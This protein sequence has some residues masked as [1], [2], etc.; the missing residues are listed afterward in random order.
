MRLLDE[1]PHVILSPCEML[2]SVAK[3]KGWTL[4]TPVDWKR[5]TASKSGIEHAALAAL[6]DPPRIIQSRLWRAQAAVLL[7]Q[8]ESQRVKIVRNNMSKFQGALQY[9]DPLD[10]ELSELERSVWSRTY[11]KVHNN[12]KYL[13]DARNDLAHLRPLEPRKALKLM[14]FNYS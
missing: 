7:P 4:H 1:K 5:G 9:K 6:E 3:E 13:R 12:V 14:Q 10:V 2:R 8:I 11:C